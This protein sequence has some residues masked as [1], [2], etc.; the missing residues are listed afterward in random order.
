MCA[1]HLRTRGSGLSTDRLIRLARILVIPLLTDEHAVVEHDLALRAA[2]D[3]RIVRN[4]NDC[5][6]LFMQLAE[7][8]EHDLLVLL[9]K[10]TGGLVG[11]NQLRIVD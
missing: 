8:V 2:G 1:F 3:Q 5:G 10:V 7:Q 4:H 11:Q 9:V 6:A